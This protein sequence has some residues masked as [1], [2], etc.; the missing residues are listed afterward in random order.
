MRFEHLE[1]STKQFWRAKTVE[2]YQH[3][4]SNYV[5][6]ANTEKAFHYA[7][8]SKYLLMG[9][10]L[11]KNDSEQLL[12][13]L[14]AT[15]RSEYTQIQKNIS[16]AKNQLKTNQLLNLDRDIDSIGLILIDLRK[17][18][19]D[20]L[21]NIKQNYPDF[22]DKNFSFQLATIEEIQRDLLNSDQTLVEYFLADTTLFIFVINELS[23]HLKKVSINEHFGE[24]IINLR[25][26]IT[27]PDR[28][29]SAYLKR[30]ANDALALYDQ[31]IAPVEEHLNQEI[32]VVADHAIALV[33]FSVL[34]T[35]HLTETT[36]H[37]PLLDWPYLIYEH[38]VSFL[39][40]ASL[41]LLNYKNNT[42][43]LY[44]KDI[45]AFNPSFNSKDGRMTIQHGDTTRNTLLP[46]LGAVEEIEFANKLF[47]GDFFL[48][49]DATESNFKNALKSSYAIFHIASHAIIDDKNPDQSKLVLSPEATD[50]GMLY[51]SE[52]NNLN[53]KSDLVIL[54]AC[55]TGVG[56]ITNGEGI[57]SLARSFTH[58]GSQNI[59]MSL[60]PVS[61]RSTTSLIKEYYKILI[62]GKSKRTSLSDAKNTFLS[63]VPAAYH[64][65]YFWGGFVYYGDDTPLRIHPRSSTTKNGLYALIGLGLLVFFYYL[66]IKK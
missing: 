36:L 39:Y 61:D 38:Q 13:G 46:L 2:V 14:P 32:I 57:N 6:V 20:I 50:D 5:A 41:E 33:P 28:Y 56:E 9:E 52:I 58:A 40:S 45:L 51:T 53:L 64:H 65:P 15:L 66:K 31:L 60:W 24:L 22:F 62:E 4:V 54:S 43:V 34:L 25:D 7:E 42:D 23:L 47:K 11:V 55:N 19:D 27:H 26:N 17:K 3:L 12:S 48:N 49:Q 37:T 16:K 30:Y 44:D 63:N 1:V 59:L 8:K 10:H 29:E 21:S 18:E 35:K